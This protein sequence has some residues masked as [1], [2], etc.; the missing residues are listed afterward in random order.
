VPD[1][2]WVDFDPTNDLLPTDRHVTTAWGA[3][4]PTSR[5]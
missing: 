4:T 3:T 1:A 5:R 2:G